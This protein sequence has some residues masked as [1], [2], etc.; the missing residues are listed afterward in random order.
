MG[1]YETLGLQRG[2]DASEIRKA[3]LRLSKTAHPD[4][5]GSEEEF[6]QIQKAYEVL[7]DDQKRGF[8]DQTGQVPGDEDHGDTHGGGMPFPFPF[9]LGGMF[10]GMFGGMGGGGGGRRQ[11]VKRPKGP[12]KMHEIGL[13][14]RDFYYGKK[15]QLKFER[16]KFCDGCR[17]EGAE[18]YDTCRVCGGSGTTEQRIM[19][20][21]GMMATSRGPCGPCSGEGKQVKKVCSKCNGLK[22]QSQEKILEVVIEPGMRSGDMLKFE[23]ECSD[24]HEYMEPGD[25]HI[26]MREADDGLVRSGDDL[27]CVVN[28]LFQDALVGGKAKVMRHPAHPDG[29]WIDIPTGSMRGDVI[30]VEGEGMPRRGTSAKGNLLCTLA[31]DLTPVDKAVL[32]KY[33]DRI[34]A[35]WMEALE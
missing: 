27:R 20:G 29:L 22:F 28:V 12:P 7:S 31:V 11:Q 9:D 8:Y 24:Q 15:V 33:K 10:G 1:L 2:A 19:I 21:P 17:G 14:L 4:K 16:Q 23:R 32:K 5:G 35:F 3:Y 34:G 26:V 25:V 18:A 30:V 13:T 6:K